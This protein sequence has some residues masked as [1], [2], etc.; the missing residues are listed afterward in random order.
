MTTDDHTPS[1][2]C[3]QRGCESGECERAAYL[4]MKRLYI[5]YSHGRRRTCSAA[6]SRAHIDRLFAADWT[7]AEIAKAAAVT[8]SMIADIRN[9]RS[10]IYNR[11]AL[12]IL[13][14]PIG[15]P[16]GPRPLDATGT[17]RRLR[18]LIRIAHSLERI[19]AETGMSRAKLSR[20]T[21]GRFD[22]I[23]ANTASC[24]ARAYRHLVMV[25]GKNSGARRYAENMGWHSPLAW[26]DIDDPAC[27]PDTGYR[28][29]AKA[30]TKP[31]V[32]ADPAR[33][34]RLTA[35][36]MSAAEIA[37]RLGCHQRTVVRIRARAAEP[38]AA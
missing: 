1:R 38:V 4:Y 19:V 14:I 15:P 32:Y 30:S 11:T 12:A 37:V 29:E 26:D 28:S 25:P 5:D 3:Y 17:V 2:A 23:D 34:A 35:Q 31:K 7:Q 13:S 27:K 36:G 24:V 10:A 18:A 16:P 6:Q 20:I 9:G 22:T 33:V 21:A 8:H